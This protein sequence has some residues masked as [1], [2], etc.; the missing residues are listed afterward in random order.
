[1]PGGESEPGES[2][3]LTVAREVREELGRVIRLNG[4]IGDA[5]QF[6]YAGTEQR[7]YEMKAAFFRGDFERESIGAGSDELHW[8]DA[9]PDRDCFFHASHA[10][11]VSQ[12]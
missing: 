2:P 6:F 11:A 9:R 8:L 1:M 10:W 3:E 5:V 7:W 12:A 4:R